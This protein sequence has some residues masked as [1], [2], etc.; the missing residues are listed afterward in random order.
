MASAFEQVSLPLSPKVGE[1]ETLTLNIRFTSTSF[2]FICVPRSQAL[3]VDIHTFKF[4][5]VCP[6]G[7][8]LSRILRTRYS[9]V[10]EGLKK[11]CLSSFST[12]RRLAGFLTRHI[13]IISLKA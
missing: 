6:R 3:K 7:G 13:G 2:Y 11:E 4:Q 5:N 10:L 1:N 9:S 12:M 8:K